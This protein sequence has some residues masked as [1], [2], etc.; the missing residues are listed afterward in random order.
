MFVQELKN[1]E[2]SQIFTILGFKMKIP[3]H[4]NHSGGKMLYRNGTLVIKNFYTK[5]LFFGQK[6]EFCL[7][8]EIFF[9]FFL[10]IFLEFFV[11]I[12]FENLSKFFT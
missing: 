5:I 6:F 2:F 8:S 9:K 10:E 7:H 12:F 11:K 4:K 1:I 3:V